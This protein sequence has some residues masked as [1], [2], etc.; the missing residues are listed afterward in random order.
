[1][2]Q[3]DYDKKLL[4]R[5]WQEKFFKLIKTRQRFVG[6]CGPNSKGYLKLINSLKFQIILLYDKDIENLKAVA[7]QNNLIKF[8]KDINNNLNKKAF[9]DLDYCCC[10]SKIEMYLSKIMKIEEFTLTVAL[11]PI[12]EEKT[13]SILQSY[14]RNFLYRV[15]REGGCPMMILYFPSNKRIL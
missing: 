8:N 11:R 15:Y 9:Y 7:P 1:M 3:P 4:K 12:S 14:N 2:K 10:I 13:L 5:K 6:L